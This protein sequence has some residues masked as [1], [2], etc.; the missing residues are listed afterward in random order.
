MGLFSFLA[1]PKPT[2]PGVTIKNVLGEVI[3]HV[4]DVWHLSG[5]I[6]LRDRDLS[7][8]DL[9]GQHLCGADLE[10]TI[11][12]GADLRNCDLSHCNLNNANLAYAKVDGATF[13][14]S[15]LDGVDLLHTNIRL[16]QLD[17][18]NITPA[19]TIPGIRVVE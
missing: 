11:L 12:L 3:D 9:R 15:D 18:A 19:S 8:A 2:P 5:S 17:E 13:R 6:C 7:F 14:R 4:D 1:A 16:T 10:N